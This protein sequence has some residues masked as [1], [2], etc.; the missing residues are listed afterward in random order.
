MKSETKAAWPKSN[1]DQCATVKHLISEGSPIPFALITRG[2]DDKDGYTV[3]TN[4]RTV[5][6]DKG[7][8]VIFQY[9]IIVQDEHGRVAVFQRE[10]YDRGLE[11]V[12]YGPSLLI[13]RSDIHPPTHAVPLLLQAKLSVGRRSVT[14]PPEYLATIWNELPMRGETVQPTYLM[15][16]YRVRVTDNRLNG[17]VRDYPDTFLRWMEPLE[18]QRGLDGFIDRAIAGLLVQPQLSPCSTHNHGAMLVSIASPI[19]TDEPAFRHYDLPGART[20]FLSHSSK[21]SFTAFGLFHF[22]NDRSNGELFPMIDMFDIRGGDI[23]NDRIREMIDRCDCIVFLITSATAASVGMR[24]EA[25]YAKQ[26]GVHRLGFWLD[27]PLPDYIEDVWTIKRAD[28]PHWLD[29]IERLKLEIL[30]RPSR[31]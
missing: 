17:L 10:R 3:F 28:Y 12:T 13:S 15:C 1:H 26:K 11:R 9:G 21:D 6:R 2:F 23:L 18:V 19:V 29:E 16:V 14:P 20:V 7:D 31:A 5:L 25:E 4:G 24:M 30:K 8:Y 27:G 22:L